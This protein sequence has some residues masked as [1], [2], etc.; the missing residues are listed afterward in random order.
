MAFPAL[1]LFNILRFPVLMLPMQIM[2]LI[3][4]RV[5][6]K[7][8][9]DFF[10]TEDR[11]AL[12]PTKGGKPKAEGGKAEGS[13]AAVAIRNGDFAWSSGAALALKNVNLEVR[14]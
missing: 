9:Q 5:S 3:N 6:F 8:V 11:E 4:A 7:R 12:P 10:D 14:P 1:S 13:E 2:N